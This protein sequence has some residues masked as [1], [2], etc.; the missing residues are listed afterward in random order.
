MMRRFLMVLAV[1][2][3]GGLMAAPAQAGG[4]T[5]TKNGTKVPVRFKNI[6][7]QPVQ[8]NAQSG[9]TASGGAALPQ[10]GFY[11]AD[12][13]P[14]GFT[15]SAKGLTNLITKTYQGTASKSPIYLYVQAD[16]TAT[17]ITVAPPF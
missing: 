14:G 17:T 11:Q 1:L 13:K 4:S 15:A 10:S 12:V 16:D 2:A 7:T 3:I 8:V 5:G 9:S 6:G